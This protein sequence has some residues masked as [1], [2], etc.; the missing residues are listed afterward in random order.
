MIGGSQCD[1][2][3]IK[4]DEINCFSPFSL[5]MKIYGMWEWFYDPDSG[6]SGVLL[7]DT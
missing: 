1:F 5:D 6:W 3:T 2:A 7:D 4:R